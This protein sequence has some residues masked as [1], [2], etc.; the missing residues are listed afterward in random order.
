MLQQV[1]VKC[2]KDVD[3][4]SLFSVG[5][6]IIVEKNAKCEIKIYLC[7]ECRDAFWN[8]FIGEKPF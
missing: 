3:E 1:C 6:C 4:I 8:D 7:C 5:G 2:G